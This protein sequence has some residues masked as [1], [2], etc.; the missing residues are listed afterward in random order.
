MLK[1]YEA[2]Y[3]RGKIEWLSK[4]PPGECFRVVIVVEQPDGPVSAQPGRLPPPELKDSIRWIGDPLKPAIPEDEWEASF[5]RTARQIA[6]D[7]E[8]FK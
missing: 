5:D 4:P 1:S 8:A 2:I 3:D 6:G 7:P